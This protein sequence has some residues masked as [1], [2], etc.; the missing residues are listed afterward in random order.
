MAVSTTNPPVEI[1]VRPVG[2]GTWQNV[3]ATP[4]TTGGGANTATAV[5][6]RYASIYIPGS[7]FISSVSFLQGLT[8]ATTKAIG[9]LFS[10]DGT[11]LGQSAAA[12][13]VMSGA[14]TFLALPLIA[15]VQVTGPA[16]FFL[17]VAFD[18]TGS[19]YGTIPANCHP[20]ILGGSSAQAVTLPQTLGNL[21]ISAT[22]FTDAQA[23]IMFIS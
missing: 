22:A 20:G 10:F 13:I 12:G 8:A 5:A 16:H 18:G 2:I 6:M 3:L 14:S 1:R 19:T 17:G 9:A 21:T 23:P 15:G 4:G 7:C 11:L